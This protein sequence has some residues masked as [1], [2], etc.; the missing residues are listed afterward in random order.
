MGRDVGVVLDLAPHGE[1]RRVVGAEREGGHHFEADRPGPELVEQLRRDLAQ[2]QALRDVPLR[3]AEAGGDRLDWLARID[4]GRH[5]D[6]FVGRVHRGP[7]RVFHQ[8]GF[9][10]LV[11]RLDQARHLVSA[12]MTPSAASS[13]RALSR[14]PPAVTA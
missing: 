1:L 3:N 12:A 8:R 9:D 10:R 11:R 2:A 7:H 4:Q 6:E 5:R 14:L 13:W